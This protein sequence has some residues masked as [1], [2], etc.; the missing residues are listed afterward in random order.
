M[1]RPA[2]EST[3]EADTYLCPQERSQISF[4]VASLC[5]VPTTSCERVGAKTP[6]EGSEKA[7]LSLHLALGVN[8]VSRRQW[9]MASG[10]V[11]ISAE[12]SHLTRWILGCLP[13]RILTCFRWWD[14]A[15]SPLH[16]CL[17][18]EEKIHKSVA[19]LS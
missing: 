1:W 9:S 3:V 7:L 4:R 2:S 13:R 14:N 18:E 5:D 17:G 16:I 19:I 10:G 12:P 15:K 8:G 6:L 11:W